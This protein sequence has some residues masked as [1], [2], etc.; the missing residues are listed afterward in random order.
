[1]G[2]RFVA[3]FVGPKRFPEGANMALLE[4]DVQA[5]HALFPRPTLEEPLAWEAL[6][7]EGQKVVLRWLAANK[8]R[9]AWEAQED[10]LSGQVQ[11]LLREA[12]GLTLPSGRVDFKA[13]KGRAVVDWEEVAK[14]CAANVSPER[15]KELL[16]QHTQTKSTRPLRAYAGRDE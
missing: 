10:A 12:P 8:A 9:K 15:Y 6:P 4:R 5:L 14:A 2:E 11:A 3:D 13:T 16:G 1:V 7:P